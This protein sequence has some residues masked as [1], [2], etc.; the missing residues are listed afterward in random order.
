MSFNVAAAEQ[1]RTTLLLRVPFTLAELKEAYRKLIWKWHPDRNPPSDEATEKAAQLN[2]A[3][4]YL[5]EILE[6]N[7]GVYRH[8]TSQSSSYAKRS[9]DWRPKRTYD[10]RSYST[11]FPDNSVTEILLKSSHIVSTGFHRPTN[12][13][14]IKF[15]NSS[16]YKYANVPEHVFEGFVNAPSHGK[17]AHANIYH[18]FQYEHC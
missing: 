3:F 6:S 1:Y 11:G 12:T 18:S 16:V 2:V 10:G 7:G 9:A 4:E 14:Y 15:S 8:V 17:F 13:L 5:S